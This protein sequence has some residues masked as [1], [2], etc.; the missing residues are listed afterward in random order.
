MD[1]D[2]WVV[3]LESKFKP[4][5]ESQIGKIVQMSGDGERYGL[6]F[7]SYGSIVWFHR[8]QI[9]P[10]LNELRKKES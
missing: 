2:D 1:V 9:E 3:V 8:S 7:T 10:Y 5:L 6:I 4:G